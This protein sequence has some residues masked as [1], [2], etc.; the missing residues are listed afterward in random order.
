MSKVTN[1]ITI[2]R[3]I[4]DVFAVL[5][6]VE[7]TGRWFPGDVEERWTSPPPHGVGSTRH[8]VVTM[9]GRRSENDA[10]T[11]AYDPPFRAAMQGTTP[12]A[13]FLV[14][15]IFAPDGVATEVKVVSEI[16]LRGPS[17][18]LGPLVAFVYGRAWARGLANLKSLMESGVL[19]G[20]TGHD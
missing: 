11:T 19:Q 7:K 10:V 20:G 16:T 4:D 12:N 9:F 18:V 3:P 13:P 8:A 14:T 17:R 5:T 15:L 2:V 1:R 6:D